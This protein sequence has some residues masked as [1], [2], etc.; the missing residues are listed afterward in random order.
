MA[1]R[2]L[3]RKAPFDDPNWPPPLPISREAIADCDFAAMI[4]EEYEWL[5]RGE[6]TLKRRLRKRGRSD[7]EID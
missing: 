6:R 5:Q 2:G 3:G 4:N 7:L 1:E